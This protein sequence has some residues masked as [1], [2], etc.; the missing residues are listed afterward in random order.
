MKELL[1]TEA[2][3][4]LAINDCTKEETLFNHLMQFSIDDFM[5]SGRVHNTIDLITERDDWLDS[6]GVVVMG[7]F[8]LNG[9]FITDL[10]DGRIIVVV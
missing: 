5:Y 6:K 3:L 1:I 10:N 7:E 2:A 8:Y 9:S 4:D